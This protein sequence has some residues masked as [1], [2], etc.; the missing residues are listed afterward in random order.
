MWYLASFSS[1]LEFEPT[2]FR[3][4]A[5]YLN[6]ETNLVSADDRPVF[7]VS[8]ENHPESALLKME[9]ENVLNRQYL[10]S[11]LFDFAQIVYRV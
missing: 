10:S 3:N 6:Y 5:R 1:T 8:F 7:T 9:G 2:A 4:P 11:E